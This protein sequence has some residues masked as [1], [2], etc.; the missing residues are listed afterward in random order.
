[1]KKCIPLL[2]VIWLITGCKAI[3]KLT[4]FNL[5]YESDITYS[6]GLP[7]NVPI[8][9]N[10]PDVATNSEQEFAI[11][12]TRKDLIQSIKLTQL[13]MVITAPAGKTF[14]FLKDVRIYISASGLPEVEVAN[15]LSIDNS[16]GAELPLTTFGTELQEYIKADTFQLRVASTTDEVVTS[17]VEVH[18][19]STFFVDA[20]ILGI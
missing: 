20:K 3:N 16:V 10:T 6:A 15:K 11:N 1:M 18:I 19:Y 12:D 13:R 8:T 14:S 2:F 5:N 7:L 17:Q 9:I 4:Q